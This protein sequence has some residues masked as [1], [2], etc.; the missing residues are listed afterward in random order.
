MVLV[1]SIW[2]AL[3]VAAASS[4]LASTSAS[5]PVVAWLRTDWQAPSLLL[6]TLD[7]VHQEGGPVVFVYL[8][9]LISSGKLSEISHASDH[10]SYKVILESLDTVVPAQRTAEDVSTPASAFVSLLKLALAT[11]SHAP[12]IQAQYRLYSDEVLLGHR[13][14]SEKTFDESCES[15]MDWYGAQICTPEG[16]QERMQAGSSSRRSPE[17]IVYPFDKVLRLTEDANIPTIILYADV[18]SSTFEALHKV[19][20]E[21]A[22]KQQIVYVLR[23]KPRLLTSE[24]P[25][26]VA[27]YGVEL[28]LKST[29]YK[30]LDD[31]D[32]KQEKGSSEEVTGSKTR[33]DDDDILR[34]IPPRTVP[35]HANETR[36]LGFQ[37]TQFILGSSN[38]LKSLVDISQNFPKF[39]HLLKDTK[40]DDAVVAE[41]R[42]NMPKLAGIK[43]R[44][45][46]NGLEKDLVHVDIFSVQRTL[47]AE[48]ALISS[49]ASL[50]ISSGQALE[51]LTTP[52]TEKAETEITWGDAFDVRSDA[53]IWWN[54]LEKDSRYN[55]WP[56]SISEILRPSY[57][58]QL[59]FI[60]KNLV[61]VLFRLDL[62]NPSHLG[63]MVQA[64]QMIP[65]DI[66]LRLGIAP[67]VDAESETSPAS[68][69]ATTFYLLKRTTSLKASKA[70][71]EQ[72]YLVGS[73]SGTITIKNIADAYFQ[74]AEKKLQPELSKWMDEGAEGGGLFAKL[75]QLDRKTGV[76]LE[77]GAI[78]AN[79]KYIDVDDTWQQTLVSTYMQMVEYLSVQVYESKIT[80]TTDLY[81]YF[82]TL[83]N[84][85][86]K[87][88]QLVFGAPRIVDLLRCDGCGVLEKL[89]WLSSGLDNISMISLIVMADFTTE[90]GQRLARDAYIYM[91]T[92]SDVRLSLL[93]NGAPYPT[94][95]AFVAQDLSPVQR[96]ELESILHKH[97]ALTSAMKIFAKKIG[98]DLGESGIVVNGRIVGPIASTITFDEEDFHL[99][100]TAERTHRIEAVAKKLTSLW[101]T[102]VDSEAT[103]AR[104]ADGIMKVTSALGALSVQ[105][106]E[107]SIEQVP[108]PR[109][110]LDAFAAVATEKSAII[111]GD[112]NTATIRIFAVVDP[113]SE[114]AQKTSAILRVLST[115]EGVSVTIVFNPE[116]KATEK[117]PITRFYRYVLSAEPAFNGE[118]ELVAPTAEFHGLP[119]EPL[120]TLGMDVPNAWLVFPTR[121]EQDLDNIRLNKVHGPAGVE[122][123]FTLENILVEG[124]ARE[125]PTNGPPRGLQFLLGTPQNPALLDTITMA[126]LGYLQLKANPGIWELRLRDGRSKDIYEISSV[127]TSF[128]D[129]L[130]SG[131]DLDTVKVVV[132]SF[133][134][135]TIFPVV[136]KKAGKENEDVLAVATVEKKEEAHGAAKL[137]GKFKSTIFGNGAPSNTTI[138]IFSVASGH[139]YERFLSIMMLSVVKQTKNPVKFWFIRNFLSPSFKA[140]IPHL[141]EAYGFEYELVTYKWPHWLRQQTEKQRTIWGYKILFLDVLFPLDLEKVIFVD[142]DQ[143][144]RTD[145]IEL[146][147][148]DLEGAVYG[149][150]PFCDDRKEMDGFRFWKNGYWKDHL[151][152]KPYHISALYVV[153]LNRFREL[154]A[155][156]RLRQQYQ[157][158]SADAGSLANLDQDL[159]NN[160]NTR[161][162][163]P[164][165]SLPQDWLWCETWCSDA[166]LKTAKTIDLCNNPLTKEP[167]LERAR[168]I[169]PEWDG[170]DK[171][172]AAVAKKAEGRTAGPSAT[173]TALPARTFEVKSAVKD[174][175]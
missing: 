137:W 105:S 66:P 10:Q 141:A 140:F 129:K 90:A 113:L 32:V 47:R 89:A 99:L 167:K 84:V 132:N 168:R 171:E 138:N 150:T 6:D 163:I 12:G 68:V 45:W 28:A 15:W 143:V 37:T 152:G 35:L 93:H 67:I 31:R 118:G 19:L 22:S 74:I 164:I 39:A 40:L 24:K 82:M 104:K 165:F 52:L 76:S 123:E 65:R 155:G 91:D 148:M 14:S 170:L 119:T 46:I 11:R 134:G 4:G 25:L 54:D 101:A 1:R 71:I 55:R 103:A 58:S 124:H 44:M 115:L 30:V 9:S 61:Q 7:F 36:A 49:L 173:L 111:T 146:V 97:Q 112:V 159:P 161:S 63:L 85:H 109:L 57:P 174:E 154:A 142:A 13:N 42:Q 56:K 20:H 175:L 29:E 149:Y 73:S 128:Q 144:V 81:E 8:S 62:S 94:S 131:Q 60:R 114:A 92:H 43:N 33:P 83:P 48:L 166:S 122:A 27:G 23:Y 130:P 2:A 38:P 64:L 145:L 160:M 50:N 117:L 162:Q 51:L 72:L 158:L 98:I 106:N 75:Q 169:L 16:L 77:Q 147:E 107:A 126:N 87:R 127:S 34:E 18:F 69:A 120:Y 21:M 121:S 96:K 116:T 153:D 17:P 78:F 59:K 88:S 53:V 70:F 86:A 125:L 100:V 41:L 136:R 5:P 139:L 156:D 135:V 110:T 3:A 151:A 80:D 133:E 108:A 95:G 26:M 79:G 102:D 157:M 172:V